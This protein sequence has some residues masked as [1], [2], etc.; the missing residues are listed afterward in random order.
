MGSP[1]EA[2]E[3]S[4]EPGLQPRRWTRRPPPPPGEWTYMMTHIRGLSRSQAHPPV[5]VHAV[6]YSP[7]LPR[8]TLTPV[9][10]EVPIVAS[11]LH[12]HVGILCVHVL[13]ARVPSQLGSALRETRVRVQ[14]R[15]PAPRKPSVHLLDGLVAPGSGGESLCGTGAPRG[16]RQRSP[17]TA[18]ALNP[19]NQSPFCGS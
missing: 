1:R 3:V 14:G 2:A 13:H 6:A 12:H 18:S 8:C 5:P 19:P 16:H 4:A 10:T 17:G 9:H 15:K 11:Q 7:H